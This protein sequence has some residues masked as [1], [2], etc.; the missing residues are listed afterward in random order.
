MV[1]DN[2]NRTIGTLIA[3]AADKLIIELHR[4][5]DNFTVVGFDDM[6]YTA[7][8]GSFV[9]IP[10][11]AKYVVA[12]VINIREK[13]L[14]NSPSKKYD[15]LNLKK[16][17]SAKY[18][19]VAPLGMLGRNGSNSFTF[20]VSTY[21]TLYANVLYAN[22]ED[23]DKVFEVA[24]AIENV[25]G[26]TRYKALNIGRSVVFSDYDVKV[27]IDEFFGGH[28]A[29]LG[30]TGSGKSST[31][32]TIL[33]SLFSKQD[34]LR[35]T[36]ATF[37]IFDVNGE[38][39]QALKSKNFPK[40]IKVSKLVL[41]GTAD[42]NK[43][44]L[45]HWFLSQEEWELLLMASERTQRPAL[46]TALCLTA[47]H[48]ES[49]NIFN[50]TKEHFVAKCIIETLSNNESPVGQMR[51]VRTLLE[52]FGTPEL[53]VEILDSYS[54][55]ERFG[56]FDDP[57]DQK[58]FLKF[59]KGFSREK[60]VLPRYCNKPFKFSLIGEC[61][62]FAILYEEAHGNRQ[63]RDYC[64]SL[65][66]RLN[67]LSYRDEFNFLK[68]ESL[69]GMSMEQKLRE[70]LGVDINSDLRKRN[71]V[72]ILDMNDVGDEVVDVVSAVI[73]RLIF[74]CLK[75]QNERNQFPVHLILE[76]AH[77]YIANSPSAYAVDASKIFERI[78][79]EGRKYGMFLLVASQ[80][81]SELSKTVLSQCTNY[82][83][84]RIQNPDDLMQ[85][86]QMTP[87]ISEN[88]LNRL[89]S[90]PK[91]HAL[92]FG[93]AVNIPSLFK[94]R[95]ANPSPKSDDAKIRELWFKSGRSEFQLDLNVI[96]GI[97]SENL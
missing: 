60:V 52:K 50:Q 75:K 69:N 88:I 57:S 11:Q 45:P 53:S 76:E 18:L 86:R 6:H 3:V 8:L 77:R 38:Y 26:K 68:D 65:I 4:R 35:A 44:T 89:P 51:R 31:V 58:K 5:I 73:S 72:V 32:A 21:P 71:Q 13:D 40:G 94:V 17:V 7:Q 67:D 79:K 10:V 25:K 36:G 20:G 48:K 46:R 23:L 92:I 90:L 16:A 1:S 47:L 49:E 85:I 64:S 82:I 37:I 97:E 29:V 41:D 34:K 87:F 56:N 42:E 24:G 70:I 93:N 43:F 9:L 84:H 81:P 74:E 91:Q 54:L 12:E 14:V 63:I 22:K 27:S 30:N 59:L 61:L 2:Q 19:E 15:N 78:A 33:Q 96:A 39:S 83:L 55:N 28:V 80:R 66:T 95:A 62:D